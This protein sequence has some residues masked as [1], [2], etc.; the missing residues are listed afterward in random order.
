MRKIKIYDTTLRDGTQAEDFN[1]SLA[2]KIRIAQKLA[3]LGIHYIEG[4]WPGSNPKDKEFFSEIQNYDLAPSLLTAFSMTHHKDS[5]PET[6]SNMSELINSRAPVVTLVGKSSLF[7]VKEILQTTPERNLELITHSLRYLQPQVKELLYDAEHFFDGHRE[8]QEYALRTLEAAVQGGAHCLVLC[9]T[10][11]GTLTSELV[12]VIKT[13]RKSFP[14]V[15][16]G[17]HAH[18]DSELAVA[19]S[20]AAVEAGCVQVQGTINGVGE[21]CGNAN[22]C[23]IIPNLQLKM[24]IECLSEAN[25]KRLSELSRFVYELANVRPNRYQPYV[26]QSAFAHKGGMHAAAV[27]R[28]PRAYEHVNPELV[29]NTRHIPV[30][31]LSGKGNI[32]LKARDFGLDLSAKDPVVA[33]TLNRIKELEFQGFQFEGAEASLELMLRAALGQR[34]EYFRLLGFRVID[35]KAGDELPPVPEVTIRVHVGGEEVHTAAEGNGPVHALDRALR[36]ALV[37]FYPRLAEM[38]LEDYKVRVLPGGGSTDA[39]VRVLIESRDANDRWGTVGVSN[40][41]IEA[42]WQALV[43]SVTFKLFKD[44]QQTKK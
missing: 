35:Q 11:G 22:L 8:D 19:N 9:D 32:I 43:D 27:K 28:N 33:E 31:E 1:L 42:S 17:I 7:Q 39:K 13:V 41:I 24:G 4:G 12:A 29:G 10:N 15:C 2:D 5:R 38:R 34:K 40:D 36:K 6:D 30:S 3:H 20:L 18:N 44:E 26:G 16:L 37:R 14:R 25:L 21:R 23:S